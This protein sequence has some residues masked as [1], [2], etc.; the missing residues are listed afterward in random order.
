MKSIF[1]FCIVL[2]VL[3][4]CTKNEV[5]IQIKNE[6]QTSILNTSDFTCLDIE[7]TG[8]IG[9]NCLEGFE[10]HFRVIPQSTVNIEEHEGVTRGRKNVFQMIYTNQGALGGLDYE[11]T[12]I[13]VFEL[14][15]SQNSFSVK[16]GELES[17]G[18]H[19][20][21]MCYCK[22]TEFKTITLGCMEGKKQSDGSWL[23]QGSLDLP[24]S[25]MDA[26]LKFEAQFN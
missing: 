3:Q 23:I 8:V 20:R 17:M 15:E 25:F 9:N 21:R 5:P 2:F 1:T 24:Y 16:D 22:E 4:S 7:E 26:D 13:L 6:A 12:N 18:V 11:T 10:C 14:D 19:F